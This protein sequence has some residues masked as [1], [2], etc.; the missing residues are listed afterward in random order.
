MR[1]SVWLLEIPGEGGSPPKWLGTETGKILTLHEGI[2]KRNR[3]AYVENAYDAIM[4]ADKQ[5]AENAVHLLAEG[6]QN[7]GWIAT[8]HVFELKRR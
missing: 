6:H 4:F 2:Q 3:I 7:N 8:E 1:K 5:S